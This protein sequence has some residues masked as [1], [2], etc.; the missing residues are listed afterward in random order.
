MSKSSV[1]PRRFVLLWLLTTAA[2]S[3]TPPCFAT[4]YAP[5]AQ[6]A[7]ATLTIKIENVSA[8][9]GTLR[10]ALYDRASYAGH[11]TDPIA[12]TYVQAVSPETIA[13]INN[14]RPGTYAI[15]MFQDFY[16]S[17]TFVRSKWGIPQEPFG[18]SNDALPLLDQPSFDTAKFSLE[19]GE[20]VI[21]IHLRGSR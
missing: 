5:L 21:V 19:R 4:N 8:K 13:T 15:K 14:L 12:A 16:G 1:T 6:D 10:I 7:G 9:G 18:F 11:S 3:V 17:E 2:L 20:N